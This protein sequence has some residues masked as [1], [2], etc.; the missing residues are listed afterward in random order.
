MWTSEGGIL[1]DD[2]TTRQQN[3][4]YNHLKGAVVKGKPSNHPHQLP[5]NHCFMRSPA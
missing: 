3:L 4:L 5:K 2:V 1:A